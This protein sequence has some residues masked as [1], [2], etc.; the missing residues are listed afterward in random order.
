VRL[1]DHFGLRLDGSEDANDVSPF[2]VIWTIDVDVRASCDGSP[3][4]P[5]VDNRRRIIISKDCA[6]GHILIVQS[7][8]HV[9]A[10]DVHGVGRD[11]AR[12]Q[13]VTYHLCPHFA[14][15]VPDAECVVSVI[16]VVRPVEGQEATS[17]ERDGGASG[18]WTEVRL[19]LL[20]DWVIVIP[21]LNL[22]NGVLLPVQ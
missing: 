16:D 2:V 20:N 14:K 1:R 4:R 10:N 17:F 12:G 19:E 21:V 22:L 3:E 8:L 6:F 13:G 11:R 9:E 5:S 15:L 7:Q 18:D